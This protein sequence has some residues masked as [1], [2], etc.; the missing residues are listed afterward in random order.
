L[1]THVKNASNIAHH[2]GCYSNVVLHVRHDVVCDSYAMFAS[3]SSLYAHGRNRPRRHAH[4]V[5]SHAPKNASN[6]PTMF[7]QTYDASFVLMCKNDKVVDRNVG[8]K[9]KRDKT[10]IWVTKSYVTNLV[11]ANK[12]WVPKTQA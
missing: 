4:H 8:P 3:S 6:K 2:D 5:A 7:Y 1:Y 9:C 12:S 11:G 10:Y